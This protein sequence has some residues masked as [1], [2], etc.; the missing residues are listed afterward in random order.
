[1]KKISEV[2]SLQAIT[3]AYKISGLTP[4]NGEWFSNGCACPAS[5]VALQSGM[6]ADQLLEFNSHPT[7]E[8]AEAIAILLGVCPNELTDFT[9]GVDDLTCLGRKP[10]DGYNHG[11]KV[12]E[13]LGF[14]GV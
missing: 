8:V 10:T 14:D 1:M 9:L 4:R 7:K 3:S 6:T 11:C 2:L 12:R 13:A 5:V